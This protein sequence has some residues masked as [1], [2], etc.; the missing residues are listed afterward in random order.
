[1]NSVI[2][3]TAGEL[4]APLLTLLSV[5]MLLRGHDAPGGGFI[6]GLL[7]A[8]A[9]MLYALACG[10]GEARRRLRVDPRT[11]I[12][13]GLALAALSG[14]PALLAGQPFMAGWWL[15]ASVPGLGKL[16][17]VL[18]FDIGVYLVVWGATLLALLALSEE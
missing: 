4:L 16:S 6:A 3:R 10:A 2:L 12:G 18:C 1:M 15:P 5:F 17:T 7:I 8:A 9:F 13:L 11:L 14:A